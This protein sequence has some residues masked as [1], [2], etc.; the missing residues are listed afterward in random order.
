MCGGRGRCTTCRVLVVAG[1]DTLPP[2]NATEAGALGRI[3]APAAVRLACQI[4]P[5]HALTVRPLIPLREAVPNAGHDAHRWGV[6][7]RITVMFADLAASRAW[8]NGST[9]TIPCSC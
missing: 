6:E 4:R 5:Q 3:H 2:P 9:P 1:A 7:R 8:R